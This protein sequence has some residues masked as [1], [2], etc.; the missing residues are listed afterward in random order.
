MVSLA[1]N[2]NTLFLEPFVKWIR[3]V[4][5]GAAN[6]LILKRLSNN[7][8]TGSYCVLTDVGKKGKELPIKVYV[9]VK[10]L[11]MNTVNFEI[12]DTICKKFMSFDANSD[13][14]NF[15]HREI[16]DK[17]IKSVKNYKEAPYDHS[18]VLE[19]SMTADSSS[20]PSPISSS[21]SSTLVTE[22]TDQDDS[23]VVML[24]KEL[25][26]STCEI[27]LLTIENEALRKKL[28][29]FQGEVIDISK[30]TVIRPLTRSLGVDTFLVEDPSDQRKYNLKET[31]ITRSTPSKKNLELEQEIST[32]LEINKS[33]L[34]SKHICHLVDKFHDFNPL[35]RSF[36]L[37]SE[38][39]IMN[40]E[41]FSFSHIKQNHSV[42]PIILTQ[43]M[44][45]LEFFETKF[46]RCH[47]NLNVK[48]IV[49]DKEWNVKLTGFEMSFKIG[50]HKDP[51][52][53]LTGEDDL[54][55]KHPYIFELIEHKKQEI[56]INYSL[57]RWSI[58]CIA[59]RLIHNKDLFTGSPSF[60]SHPEMVESLYNIP[61]GKIVLSF[62]ADYRNTTKPSQ[63]LEGELFSR[64]RGKSIGTSLTNN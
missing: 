54:L 6:L 29:N 20:S 64:F 18:K 19:S 49:V 2:P 11:D 50:E 10:R 16:D 47:G 15:K 52:R 51:L 36:Y 42:V 32:L 33:G 21:S 60:R 44:E 17:T 63:Y 26:R 45:G 9:K 53:L 31:V 8:K 4:Y 12:Y 23:E 34:K 61:F 1:D 46:Q 28:T 13:S 62:L 27:V 37:I 30:V 22:V 24:K 57:D 40:L 35:R 56:E 3:E 39:S 25:E 58:G 48:T 55:Y 43:I 38:P 41:E 14:H 59:Y 7:K 5:Q